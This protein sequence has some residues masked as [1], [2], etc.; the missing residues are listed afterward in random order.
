MFFVWNVLETNTLIISS[1]VPTLVPLWE[2]ARNRA[3]SWSRKDGSS[4]GNPRALDRS[5][6]V[7]SLPS[8][9][10][11]SHRKLD[12]QTSSSQECINV[13]ASRTE[14]GVSDIYDNNYSLN[15]TAPGP[16]DDVE[17]GIHVSKEWDVTKSGN[18]RLCLG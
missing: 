9:M 8:K 3:R 17:Q 2:T 6:P 10:P 14:Q 18:A 16:V 15:V 13:Q 7:K 5:Y 1:C 4:T 11:R 12:S